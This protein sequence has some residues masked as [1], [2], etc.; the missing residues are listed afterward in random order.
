MNVKILLDAEVDKEFLE[1]LGLKA[2]KRQVAEQVVERLMLNELGRV[3]AYTLKEVNG[4]LVTYG[5]PF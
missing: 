4:R 2:T 5:E 1:E 3:D